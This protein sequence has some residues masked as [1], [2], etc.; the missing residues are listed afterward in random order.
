MRK[1]FYVIV[2]GLSLCPPAAAQLPEDALR[3]SWTMPGG[4]AREQA[5]G[6]A[7]GSLG[8]DITACFINP[9]GIALYKTNEFVLSPGWRL[10][11]TDRGSY[12]G[13]NQTGP[14]LNRFS[15]GA[16]GIVIALPSYTPGTSNTL[17]F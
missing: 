3:N 11:N 7:M 16:S 9:A 2:I 14:A 6:G 5:I 4:T 10:F 13:T 17:A 15:M 12:L 8:G 1:Y